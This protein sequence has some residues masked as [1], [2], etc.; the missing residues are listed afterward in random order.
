MSQLHHEP[1]VSQALFNGVRCTC[2]N[3]GEGKLFRRF[4]K[5]TE[6]CSV[7]GEALHHHRADD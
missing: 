6:T 2:P 1:T 4:L 7:C 5:V 3:C